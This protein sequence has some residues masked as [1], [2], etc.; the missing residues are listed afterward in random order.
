[1]RWEEVYEDKILCRAHYSKDRTVHGI[2]LIGPMHEIIERRRAE[3]TGPY[4]FSYADGRPIGSYK[5]AWKG[6]LKRAGLS[7][8]SFTISAAWRPR[9]YVA[10]ES[11]KTLR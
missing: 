4:V 9:S 6:A 1:L 8:S 11:R 2:P 5:N 3:R 7:G 10:A